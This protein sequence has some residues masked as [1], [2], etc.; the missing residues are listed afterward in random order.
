VP[1]A[2]KTEA[3]CLAAVEQNSLSIEFV[4]DSL[5]TDNMCFCAVIADGR[6]LEFV[7]EAMKT[8]DICLHAVQ[9]NSGAFKYVPEH[10]KSRVKEEFLKNILPE[11]QRYKLVYDPM[12]D[13]RTIIIAG[14]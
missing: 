10:L 7:P 11:I 9:K 6:M 3:V 12:T 8:E 1:E 5:K 14:D 4:P 2:F 13:R